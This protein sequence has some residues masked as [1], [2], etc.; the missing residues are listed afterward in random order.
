MDST[1]KPIYGNQE[2]AE[3]GYN[4]NKRGRP[5]HCYHS[6][7]IANL[8]LVLGVDVT[9]GNESNSP[10][11]LPGLLE[12]LDD[13]PAA[14]RP[15]LVRADRGYGNDAMM[16]ALEERGQDYL[17]K[18]PMRKRAKELVAKLSTESGWTDL[19]SKRQYG[20]CNSESTLDGVSQH[21]ANVSLSCDGVGSHLINSALPAKTAE[22]RPIASGSFR[23]DLIRTIGFGNMTVLVTLFLEGEWENLTLAQL[24]RDRGDAENA[25]DELKNQW[26]WGGF[27]TQDL[28]RTQVTARMTALVYNWWS[29]FVRL[30]EPMIGREAITSRP[31]LLTGVCPSD[32]ARREHNIVPQQQPCADAKNQ[33][34]KLADLTHVFEKASICA[35]VDFNRA[36]VAAFSGGLS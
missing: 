20:K 35:A 28:K 5:S 23:S 3:V 10:Y 1:V 34:Q 25:F 30:I 31:L 16:S 9:P 14:M 7:L 22:G 24:Y 21:H 8:R 29:L 27:T 18:L 13:L 11:S 4:P 32:H 19:Q 6:Y 2:G 15:F 12:I 26:G 36:L 33:K 17:L